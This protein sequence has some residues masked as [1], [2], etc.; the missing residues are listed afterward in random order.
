MRL[1][2]NGDEKTLEASSLTIADLLKACNVEMPDTVSVQLNREFV[3]REDFETAR[4]SDGDEVDFLYFM[5]GGS[6]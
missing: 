2:V 4:A 1:T 5:G 6:R 3:R